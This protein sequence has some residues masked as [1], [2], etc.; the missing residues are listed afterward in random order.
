MR[1]LDVLLMQVP[2]GKLPPRLE[3]ESRC[4]GNPSGSVETVLW[5]VWSRTS[6]ICGVRRVHAALQTYRARV[7]VVESARYPI[8]CRH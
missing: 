3:T 4:R 1:E 5:H 2:A 6:L 7:G 8:M